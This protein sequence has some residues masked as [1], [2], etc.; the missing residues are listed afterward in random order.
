MD[1]QK[2][3]QRLAKLQEIIDNGN[4]AIARFLFA[5]EDNLENAVTS[6]QTAITEVATQTA[7]SDDNLK[8]EFDTFK[9]TTER[10]L[11]IIKPLIPEV[12]DGLTPSREDLLALISPLIPKVENGKTPSKAE[13][14]ALI[15]PLIPEIETDKIISE[16]VSIVESRI[17]LPS[18]DEL[19][20]RVEKDLPKLGEPV[21]D[22][23]ELLKGDNRLDIS[24]VKGLD[25]YD[26]ISELARQERTIV[27]KYYGGGGSG[28]E[29]GA[30]AY[31]DLTDVDMTGLADGNMPIWDADTSKWI[32]GTPTDTDEKVK[33]DASDPTA[34]YVADKFVAG[35]GIT[36]AEGTGADENKLL[37]TNSLD[38]SGYVPYTGAIA[39]LNLGDYNLLA[40]GAVSHDSHGF[41]F[42]NQSLANVASFG[43]GG[44]QN[45]TFYDGVKLDGG[46][47]SRVLLTDA[48]KNISYSTL[49]SAE[50][51]AIPT[52]YAKL[53]GSNHPFTY[54][55]TP[56]IYPS[57]DST[58]AVR[59]LKADGITSMMTFDT[60]NGQVGVGMTPQGASF[61]IRGA[62]TANSYTQIWGASGASGNLS[63]LALIKTADASGDFVFSTFVAGG[64]LSSA[65]KIHFGGYD[66]TPING[67][68]I[69]M[70]IANGRLGIGVTSPTNPFH[71][72]TTSTTPLNIVSSDTNTVLIRSTK[73]ANAATAQ[74]QLTTVNRSMVFAST[75]QASGVAGWY[76]ATAGV[77]RMAIIHTSG[78]IDIGGGI[79][80]SYKLNVAGTTA[81]NQFLSGG[82]TAG[83]P[84]YTFK[85]DAN[86]GIYNVSADVLGFA[87]AGSTRMQIGATGEIAV[88][89]SP[90]AGIPF[91]VIKS[92]TQLTGAQTNIYVDGVHTLNANNAFQIRGV[93]SGPAI[94][95]AGFNATAS[96]SSGGAVPSF[97]ALPQAT[98]A[99][100]TVT[101][102]TGFFS[103]ARNTGAG[104]VS[105][106][107]G[108][109]AGAG[110]NT[111]GGSVTNVYGFYAGANTVGTNNY[112]FYG[113]TVA[114]SGR[115]GFYQ[116]GGA[117]N[118]FAGN[119]G[120]GI[121]PTTLLHVNVTDTSAGATDMVKFTTTSGGVLAFSVSDK[122]AANPTWTLGSG[123]SEPFGF[124]LGGVTKFTIGSSTLTLPEA[125]NFVFGTTTGTKIGTATTQKIGFW[126]ATPIV[127][128]T[129]AVTA[130]TF[131]A[132]TS[133]IVDDTATFDGYTIGQVVAALRTSGLLA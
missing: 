41:Y 96:I 128:P 49:T 109:S 80:T 25:D 11:E 23:L 75:D 98:G 129:T 126:N 51:E 125:Q 133:G 45:W 26:E 90:S 119:V 120:I 21:R 15:K 33:Y 55:I 29:G 94:N 10:L 30:S 19:V 20:A 16:V 108:F 107:I 57:A 114:S 66:A 1:K 65:P 36:L 34:G 39:D 68:K 22:S 31:A 91:R 97:Y 104:I 69:T 28:S 37:I 131:A 47:A 83:A 38:L 58:T 82:G 123:T 100:G 111:G 89:T 101:N 35:T 9:P 46:T 99:S 92:T 124:A 3:L 12:K 7:Q 72:S 70:D 87:T 77:W 53:D 52:T 102:V 44:G 54:V 56:K 42:K 73:A 132:N 110:L 116:A 18:A 43:L 14:L 113:T 122:S 13:L 5:L 63:T 112:E 85:T 127:Q 27:K 93:Y 48:S 79:A 24:A 17:K 103:S 118:Y 117:N 121:T 67:A 59:I 81:G 64:A 95:Q 88:G 106:L 2:K 4:P 50:L 78:N 40:E 74:V 130:A 61:Q 62:T 60:T 115:W 32:P 71:I 8:A 84:A 6:I 86:T 105:E 76:D